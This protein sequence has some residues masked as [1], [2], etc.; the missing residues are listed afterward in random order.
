MLD[1]R[2]LIVQRMLLQLLPLFKPL[3]KTLGSTDLT[4]SVD[5]VSEPDNLV[6]LAM[7][8]LSLFSL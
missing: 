8:P 5:T 7:M 4:K 3:S 1:L 2:L 6:K